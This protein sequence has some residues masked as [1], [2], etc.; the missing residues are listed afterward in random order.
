M[1]LVKS[2]LYL[3][4]VALDYHK[5]NIIIRNDQKNADIFPQFV[6]VVNKKAYIC[7]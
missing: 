5:I 7:S 4:Y 2:H 1:K 6:C 3:T